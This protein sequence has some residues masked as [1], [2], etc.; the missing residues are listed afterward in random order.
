[1]R[2]HWPDGIRSGH[3]NNR[4]LTETVTRPTSPPSIDGD[5]PS[6]AQTSTTD[7]LAA[8]SI[9]AAKSGLV[10]SVGRVALQ[11]LSQI[12]MARMLGPE[13][14]GIFGL[15]LVAFTFTTFVSEFGFGMVL[16]QKPQLQDRDI[17]LVFTWQMTL[18]AVAA[19]C[20][21]VVAPWLGQWYGE[22]QITTALQWMSLACL[23]N[24]AAATGTALLMRDLDF[25]AIG[26]IDLVGYAVGYLGVGLAL[27][28]TGHGVMA[29]IA[30]WLVHAA[31]RA[32][33]VRI[34]RPHPAR[35]LW[36]GEAGPLVLATGSRVL[37]TN[38]VNWLLQNVDRVII[39]RLLSTHAVGVYNVG[40]NLATTAGMLLVNALQPTFISGG[41]RVQQDP[42][43]LGRAWLQIIATIWII[44]APAFV[45][46]ASIAPSVIRLLYGER[47]TDAAGVLAALLVGMPFYLTAAMSTPVLWNCQQGH[48]EPLLQLPVLVLGAM[49]LA[50]FTPAGVGTAAWVITG[51]YAARAL[52]L[53][54]AAARAT[55]VSAG[56]VL[57]PVVRGLVVCAGAFAL[58]RVTAIGL[59]AA[60]P[61]NIIADVL[62]G[63][64]VPAAILAGL[65]ALQP[66]LLGDDATTMVVRIVPALGRRFAR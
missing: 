51:I 1:M 45:V 40:N 8:R 35:L 26:L 24:A 66:T 55:G 48:R 61:G 23:L 13:P 54:A 63:G 22:P 21:L 12:L 50:V 44:A 20:L 52:V 29:L 41:A 56:R 58:A 31:I 7:D 47:W 36:R 25:R 42:E 9:R 33:L 34:R 59:D 53:A 46:A 17:R 64:A 62:V 57:V 3:S 37:F 4:P 60:L 15:A 49:A 19:L 38:I 65:V 2:N 11:F 39:G 30:A 27:A 16:M 43:R 18:G 28:Y 14:F 10:L 32:L 6:V 5:Q